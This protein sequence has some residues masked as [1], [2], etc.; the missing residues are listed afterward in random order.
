[1]N[2]TAK[3]HDRFLLSCLLGLFL[4]APLHAD[5]QAFVGQDVVELTD[6]TRIECLVVMESTRGVLVI[7]PDPEKGE[8]AH[9]QQFIPASQIKSVTRGVRQGETKAFQTDTELARKVIQG[10]GLRPDDK[11]KPA[12]PVTPTGPIAPVT[13]PVAQK[14]GPRPTPTPPLGQGKGTLPSKDLIEAYLQRFPALQEAADQL[15]GGQ[16][17]LAEGLEKALAEPATR[18][19]AERML[20][21]FFQTTRTEAT[22][23]KTERPGSVK[24]APQLVKP[25]PAAAK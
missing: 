11:A 2:I 10:S 7:R 18:Q 3:R 19:E 5:M 15:L 25:A 20:E 4:S 8:G 17:Q 1:V 22:P 21:L 9:R 24:P 14:P 16:T 12:Q 6:G 13:P 23:V